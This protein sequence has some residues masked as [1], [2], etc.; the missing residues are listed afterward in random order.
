[1][2]KMELMYVPTIC[3][4]CGVGCGLNLVVKDGRLVGVEPW[5]RHPVN[6]GKLC[7]K[8]LACH[9]FVHSADR[10][11]TPLIKK[12]GK[13]V[14][15]T[16]EEALGLVASKLKATHKT[17][18]SNSVAF[19]VSCRVSNEEAYLMGKLARV[20]FKTNNVDNCARVCH[21][22][23]VTGLTCHLVRALRQIPW[24]IA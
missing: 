14:E 7:P 18:G 12:D 1:M 6:E 10:L 17:Y 5:K 21:G 23:S 15:V 16:W 8:G 9:Q 24:Q 22:P 2:N 20:G 13:F 4:Y 19:Q 3:P 11:T